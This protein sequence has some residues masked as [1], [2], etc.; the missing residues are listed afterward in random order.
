MKATRVK[1]GG[2]IDIVAGGNIAAGD[3][4][5]VGTRVGVA[6][7][8][9]ANG[10]LGAVTL[11]GVFDVVSGGTAFAVGALVFW[12]GSD[13]ATTAGATGTNNLIGVAIKAA[14]TDDTL[15][16]VLLTAGGSYTWTAPDG[17]SAL[18]LPATE[19]TAVG[20]LTAAVEDVTNAEVIA[21]LD[22]LKTAINGIIAALQTAKLMD[23]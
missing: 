20:T 19:V 17:V 5:V 21:D 12:D 9:I 16:R 11:E 15:V 23:D 4:V 18:V 8:P 1:D 2:I 13:V 14:T 10:A 22:T 3:I 6:T 7:A